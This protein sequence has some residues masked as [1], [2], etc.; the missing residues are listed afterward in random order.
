[1]IDG[2]TIS[3]S[4][5]FSAKDLYSIID[6]WLMDNRYDKREIRNSELVRQEGK[7]IEIEL[8]PWRKI[9][10]YAK[11][12]IKVRV[13]I[14]NMTHVEVEKDGKKVKMDKGDVTVILDGY[15]TTDYENVWEAKPV[16]YFLRTLFDKYIYKLY[17]NRFEAGLKSDVFHLNRQIK[18]LLNVGRYMPEGS[19]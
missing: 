11:Y 15:L 13:M 2:L 3:F 6:T 18:G 9:T 4:G 16:Y 19:Y 5:L 7:Y 17:T 1:M 10:D 12:E 8:L 14:K